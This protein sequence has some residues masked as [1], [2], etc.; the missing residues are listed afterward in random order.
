MH[1]LVIGHHFCRGV[2]MCRTSTFHHLLM[3]DQLCRPEALHAVI[4]RNIF[5]YRSA[6]SMYIYYKE[7]DLEVTACS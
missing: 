6:G 3:T 5:S 4:K 1:N 7:G 2:K